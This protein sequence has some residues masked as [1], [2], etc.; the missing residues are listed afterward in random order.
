MKLAMLTQPL[1]I[2]PAVVV[3]LSYV[4]LQSMRDLTLVS[5][6]LVL[7]TLNIFF[8]DDCVPGCCAM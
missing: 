6:R 5:E 7:F 3:S 4:Q 8:E 1:F 2:R